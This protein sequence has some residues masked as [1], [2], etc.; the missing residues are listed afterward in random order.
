M[1]RQGVIQRWDDSKG[2]G[3][4]RPHD[5]GPDLFVHASACQLRQKQRP[6]PGTEVSFETGRGRDGRP[7]AVEVLPRHGWP[8]VD[9]LPAGAVEQRRRNADE[10]RKTPPPRAASAGSERPQRGG[11]PSSAVAGLSIAALLLVLIAA[12]ASHRLPGWIWAWHA[13][14]SLLCFALYAADKS[15]ARA[16]RWRTPE[17]TLLTVGLIGGWPG[18]LAAQHLLRHKSAK[19]SFRAAFHLTVLVQLAAL[20]WLAWKGLRL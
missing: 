16:G 19:P 13:A 18:G 3:F 9:A 11:G 15:A 8:V 20:S 7:Q 10:A 17:S 2:F 5:G 14:A 1:R 6:A 4:I 12:T